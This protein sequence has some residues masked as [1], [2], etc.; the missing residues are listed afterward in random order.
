MIISVKLTTR[1]SCNK[2]IGFENDV[3]KVSC[4]AV[5]EKGK[6][7]AVLI[8]LLAD[9]YQVPKSNISIIKGKTSSKKLVQIT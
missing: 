4:T 3:L 5:P 7:N 1:A 9:Y 2:V 6:A 8:A